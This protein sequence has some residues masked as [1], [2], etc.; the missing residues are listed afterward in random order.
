MTDERQ[1]RVDKIQRRS[2]RNTRLRAF[3]CNMLC[4]DVAV[5]SS[6]LGWLPHFTGIPYGDFLAATMVLGLVFASYIHSR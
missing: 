2:D 6:T 5:L 3:L 4:F 1:W